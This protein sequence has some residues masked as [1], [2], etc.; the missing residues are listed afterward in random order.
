[1]PRFQ[2]RVLVRLRP[3]VLDPAGEAARGAAERLGVEGISKLRIGKAV[4]IELDASDEAEA[5]RR[6]ELLSD[7]LLSNP[8]IEDWTLELQDS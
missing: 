3:S 2:A 4:E 6:L 8:V 7:R 1:M 5:R